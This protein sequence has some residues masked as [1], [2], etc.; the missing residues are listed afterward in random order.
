MAS[1]CDMVKS[2]VHPRFKRFRVIDIKHYRLEPT[3][4]MYV[5][6]VTIGNRKITF[7]ACTCNP[8][9]LPD[10]QI[11][12]GRFILPGPRIR[13]KVNI[14]RCRFQVLKEMG[15][16]KSRITISQVNKWKGTPFRFSL[17]RNLRHS[18]IV[19]S[20]VNKSYAGSKFKNAT[21]CWHTSWYFE[22]WIEKF[23]R[24]NFDII[25]W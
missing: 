2:C 22:W 24:I 17:R 10:K 25:F 20:A 13:I 7:L 3:C 8:C 15:L 19:N 5:R 14:L 11:L 6:M 9:S 21:R 18:P 1:R 23:C 12:D 4:I 16:V